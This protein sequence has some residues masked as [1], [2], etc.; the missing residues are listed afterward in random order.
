MR[1]IRPGDIGRHTDMSGG[2]VTLVYG[3]DRI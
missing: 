3:R 1:L 2:L